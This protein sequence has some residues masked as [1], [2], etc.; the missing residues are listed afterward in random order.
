MVRTSIVAFSLIAT[1]LLAGCATAPDPGEIASVSSEP[2]PDRAAG[3]AMIEAAVRETLKDPDSAQ[4]SWPHGF[5]QGW[6]QPP[7]G[8]KYYGWITCGTVNARNS[9]GGYV[10]RTPVIGVIRGGTVIETNMD[11]ATAQYGG[12]VGEACRK[13]GVPA[14]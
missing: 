8:K 11:D 10:G 5:V 3:I 6:Y 13:I 4:F 7:F 12:F 1:G 14:G 2:A 9:F